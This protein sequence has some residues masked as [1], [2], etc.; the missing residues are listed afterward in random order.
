MSAVTMSRRLPPRAPMDL[1]L[2]ALRTALRAEGWDA[3]LQRRPLLGD[4]D[5]R[6]RIRWDDDHVVELLGAWGEQLFGGQWQA[7][8]ARRG[9]RAVWCGP[10]RGCSLEELVAFVRDL[11]R[12]ESRELAD[13]Y[14]CRS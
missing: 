4:D 9:S 12:C 2:R 14:L 6:L 10:A 1:D 8:R 11:M 13:R 5:V 3:R 7:V